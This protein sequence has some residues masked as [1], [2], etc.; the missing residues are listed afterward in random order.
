MR[1]PSR[2][3]LVLI[4]SPLGAAC[5]PLPPT[6][7][8][9]PTVSSATEAVLDESE[10]PLEVAIA[11]RELSL[12]EERVAFR[13]RD[14]SG[15]T[16]T[17]S[18]VT[19]K[20]ELLAVRADGARSAV[21]QGPALYFGSEFSDGGSWV[22]YTDFD[23][24]G[25][26]ILHVTASRSDGWTAAGEAVVH[27][28]GRTAAPRIGG[29]PPADGDARS[30]AE[31]AAQ[32]SDPQPDPDLYQLSVSEAIASGRPTL[33]VL[34]SPGH[35]PTAACRETLAEVKAVKAEYQGRVNFVHVETRDAADP[36]RPA[37]AAAAWQLPSEPWTYLVDGSGRIVNRIEG[38]VDR[39]ELRALLKRHLGD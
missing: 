11:N 21:A 26:W 31:R 16:L 32:S 38:P 9:A 7:T 33:I 34:G 2:C 18:D 30:P 15:R 14:G 37:P 3:L 10:A 4:L 17:G 19:V 36:S 20:A 25:D 1:F 39:R 29:R 8:P 6:I 23:S 35:C 5:A 22:T 24:S 13:L 28:A 27:V 12:G